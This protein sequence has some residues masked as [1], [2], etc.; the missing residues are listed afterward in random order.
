MPT[1]RLVRRSVVLPQLGAAVLKAAGGGIASGLD[2]CAPSVAESSDH[3]AMGVVAPEI[4][5]AA[6]NLRCEIA[7]LVNLDPTDYEERVC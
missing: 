4:S 1:P 3:D 5:P 2:V 6:L 7:C